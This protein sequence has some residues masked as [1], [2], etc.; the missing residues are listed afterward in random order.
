MNT[1]NQIW[2]G[3][4]GHKTYIVAVAAVIYGAYAKDANIILL[5][6]GMAGIRQGI[7]NEVAK[8]LVSRN[9]AQAVEED[10]PVVAEQVVTALEPVIPAP[11]PFVP[12]QQTPVVQQVPTVVQ[13]YH[14]TPEAIAAAR[15][16][17][18]SQAPI[19]SV[20]VNL[21]VANVPVNTQ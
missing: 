17:L 12:A 7:S 14:Y 21:P 20:P 1:I 5:G 6:L 2:E 11:A 4:K 15:E 9:V 13:G 19:A 10:V 3:L 18:A 16:L 8:V